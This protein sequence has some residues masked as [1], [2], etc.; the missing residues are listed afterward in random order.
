MNLPEEFVISKFYEL[1]YWVTFSKY[2]QTY[3]CAC[4]ICREGKSFHKKKR[5]YYLPKRDLIYCHNCGWSSKPYKW[6]RQVSG[7]TDADILKELQEG[8]YDVGID[9]GDKRE[10]VLIEVP[11]LP[12]DCINLSDPS[13]VEYYKENNIV[14]GA[15]ALIK[16]RRL[17]Q[18]VNRCKNLYISLKDKVHRHRLIIPFLDANGDIVHYQSRKIFPF[19]KKEKYISKVN[20]ERTIFNLD[21]VDSELDDVFIFEGPFDSFFVKNGIAVGGI[22][23]SKKLFSARQE[24]QMEH[25]LRF[26][27]RI[28]VLDSQWLDTTSLQKTEMLLNQNEAVFIWPQHL[29]SKYK[30]FNETCVAVGL[31]EI[32][33]K[34]IKE[35]A[36]R[37]LEG[38]LKLKEIERYVRR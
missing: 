4:P 30:D 12:D 25:S 31:N 7:Q 3:N 23:E 26:F 21:R 9:W 18:A 6:I 34:F 14:R 29:G 32:S 10:D 28:W 19:D 16:E 15:L 1:G 24:E 13:Q 27:N 38:V 20:S 8:D 2:N 11:T 17:D 35:N 5:C 37:S 22:N 36:F 33:S